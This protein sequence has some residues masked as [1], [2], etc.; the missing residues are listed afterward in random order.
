[1]CGIFGY[2]GEREAT[3][4]VLEGLARLEYRGYDS[5]GLAVMDSEHTLAI[6]KASGKLHNLISEVNEHPLSG[7]MGLGHTRWAT[8][9]IASDENA[10][11]HSDCGNQVAVVHNG[12]VEN[13]L[14]L[15]ER[16][17][18]SGHT[19]TSATDSEVVGHLI[20]E[21]L[22][23]GKPFVEAIRLAAAELRGAH[24][25]ASLYSGEPDTL[26]TLRI[27]HA[28]GVC[29]GYGNHEMFLA[30]DLPALLPLT[31][32]IA[33]L[34]PGQIG[35]LHP[36]GCSYMTLSGEAVEKQPQTMSINPIAA[37]KGGHKHFM[38]KEILEQPEASMSALRGRL[39]FTPESIRLD[40]VPFSQRQLQQLQRVVLLGMGSSL[41]AAQ[42][43]AQMIER[44]ARLP[45]TAENASEFRYRKPVVDGHTLLISVGQSG[46]TADT[47]EAMQE[48]VQGGA[49]TLT[50]CNVEGS[51][52]TRLAQGAILMHAGPEVAV[53]ASKTF[54]SSMT[55]LYMLA[56][57]LGAQRGAVDQT[58]MAN[59]VQNLAQLP[60]LLGQALELNRSTYED[61]TARYAQYRRFLFIGRGLLEPLAREGAMK[62]KEI[63]YIH[64]EGLPAAELKHGPIALVDLETPVVA[65]ALQD[66]LY[67][68][69]L[70]NINEVK[71]R[72]GPVL[73]VATEGD[74]TITEHA[75]HVLWAPPCPPLLAPMVTAVP[76]Q[77]FAY[78]TA[79]Y[80]GCDVDQPRNLAKSVTVE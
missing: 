45:A 52:A 71:S 39:S 60:G 46:E 22:A 5:A 69:M 37:A 58:A 24:A 27:G 25:I 54:T 38:L 34:A 19:F 77:C 1:M 31:N 28:G 18:A 2:L 79:V 9:G 13:Y 40:E 41:H 72:N 15:K 56:I 53:A 11:P 57:Y 50:V 36:T 33:F 8:H 78:H 20:E 73:A 66:P 74:M 12:I 44:L 4:L 43:G 49:C 14:E 59:H 29:V 21:W 32:S 76:L 65:L 26:V 10:H 47:L 6:R 16:L 30:S 70:G 35:T 64:A 42:V 3:P 68:K 17:L 51:Q 62:L 48:G 75:D 55:C 67:D 80:C 63:S 7:T 61:L 23:R